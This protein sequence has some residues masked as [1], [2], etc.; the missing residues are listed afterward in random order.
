MR[1]G[2]ERTILLVEDEALIALA[3]QQMLERHGYRVVLASSGEKA[4]A[5]ATE[6]P[7]IELVLMDID[8]GRGMDGTEAAVRI[9]EDRD[10]PIVF[11]S[12]HTE[13]SIVEST[14]RIT[15]YGYIVKNSGETVLTTS[16]KMAFRLFE[17]R[18][19][20]ADTFDHSING[21]CVHR[22][23]YDETG[24]PNDCEYL[25]V[26]EAFTRKTGFATQQLIGRT[27]RDLY[28]NDEARELIDL[29]IDV[30]TSRTPVRKELW[31]DPT[32]SW[33][34]LSIFPTSDDEFTV[35]VENITDRI[36]AHE[37]LAREEERLRVTLQSVGDAV[38]ATDAAGR[39]TFLNPIAEQLTGITADAATDR[40]LADVFH[41]IN[42]NTRVRTENPV[43]RVLAEGIIVGMANHTVLVSANG[44]EYQIADSAAPIRDATGEVIGVVLVFR[45]VTEEYAIQQELH[46]REQEMQRAQKLANLGS[47]RFNLNSGVVTASAQAYRIYGLEDDDLTIARAQTV[48]LQHY[49]E[50]LDTALRN[51]V[52]HGAPYDVEF[53]ICRAN[54][55]ET[56]FIHSVAEYDSEHNVVVGTLH[57]ITNAKRTEQALREQRE[58]FATITELSPIGITAVDAAGVITYANSAAERILGLHRDE[59]TARTYD[60]PQWEH[61]SPD[62][63]PF[64]DEKQPFAI[65]KRTLQPVYDV[66]HGITWPDGRHVELSINASPI[67][68][69]GGSFHGMVATIDDITERKQAEERIQ[70]LLKEK[71]TL[72]QEAYHRIAGE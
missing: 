39:V 26:N 8:L 60:A 43:E 12:S 16:L 59:I 19:L 30:M 62:G 61:T 72:L 48:P 55:G 25:K 54:D 4:V 47:W 22:L 33:Y 71:E 6:Q 29:Y 13:A 31:F 37:R 27:I 66:R 44:T 49:R 24:A 51:L 57:D 40:P 1:D 5:I 38:I 3:E 9:L 10:L 64:P 41:I 15:S 32:A 14:E 36:L 67:L 53:E 28:P 7:E 58:R 35:V 63:G 20:T 65:V 56:R 42:A 45:D 21:L 70:T 68:G 69:N 18:K 34:E 23:L 52:E 11:L 2:K 17:S 50:K 46:D